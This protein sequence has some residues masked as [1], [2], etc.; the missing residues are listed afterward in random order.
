M[1]FFKK[2]RDHSLLGKTIKKDKD[3]K[4]FVKPH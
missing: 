2:F 1:I 3:K 4:R